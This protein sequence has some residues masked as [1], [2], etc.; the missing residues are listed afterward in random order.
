MNRAALIRAAIILAAQLALPAAAAAHPG[1]GEHLSQTQAVMML[2][3]SALVLGGVL[4][5]GMRRRWI[6]LTLLGVGL[7]SSSV[8]V[9]AMPL[10]LGPCQ[11]RPATAATLEV[12]SPAEGQTFAGRVP[13]RVRV[14]GGR[15]APSAA[16]AN[17][18]DEGHLHIA[19]DGQVMSMV[20]LERQV[21]PVPLGAHR[22]TVEFVANDHLAYCPP[23]AV[24]RQVTVTASP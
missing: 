11:G 23:V 5:M 9:L 7:L 15:L 14:V 12:L 24:T 4:L 10:V 19:I 8:G 16:L 6:P 1:H 18:P 20:G 22:I 13:V 2:A 3:G 21:I 17:Q